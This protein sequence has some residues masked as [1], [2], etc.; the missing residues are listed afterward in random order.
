M[1]K[2]YAVN[3]V[4]KDFSQKPETFKDAFTD[5]IRKGARQLLESAFKFE[6]DTFIADI[7]FQHDSVMAIR[8]GFKPERPVMTGIGPITIKQPRVR[9]RSGEIAPFT[10]KILPPYLR[11]TKSIEELIPCLYLKGISSDQFQEALASLTGVEASGLSATTVTRLKSSWEEDMTSWRQQSLE[12]KRYVYI[13]ADGIHFNIRLTE[14]ERMC[15]LVVIGATADGHKELLAI[16][17]GYR[18]SEIS[19]KNLLMSLRDRKLTIDPELAIADGALG[20][21]K[22]LP[23]VFPKTK[24]QRCWVHKTA[25]VLEKLPKSRQAEA[26]SHLHEIYNNETKEDAE[27]AFDRFIETWSPTYIKA[28]NCLA[29]DKEHLLNFYNFPKEHWCHIRTTNPIES[30]FAYVRLRTY[31]TKGLGS[32]KATEVMVFKLVQSAEKTWNKLRGYERLAEVIDLRWK[33]VNGIRTEA[34]AA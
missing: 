7:N 11:K 10:S 33:F 3:Q 14:D 23:Q 22:A 32:A 16:E 26:K 12:G 21:W 34:Q 28:A 20:F 5:I 30:T 8:N 6:V 24:G 9:L 29:K 17:S 4:I 25:N 27:K 13:W 18:E 19:W 2:E 15:I 1:E 31:K